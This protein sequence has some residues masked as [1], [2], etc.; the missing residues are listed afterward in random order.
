MKHIEARDKHIPVDP[1]IG[2]TTTLKEETMANM[3]KVPLVDGEYYIAL[4]NYRRAKKM[5]KGPF[6]S[7]WEKIGLIYKVK[8]EETGQNQWLPTDMG[9]EYMIAHPK[10]PNAYGLYTGELDNLLT[11]YKDKFVAYYKYYEAEENMIK[12]AKKV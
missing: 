5:K 4:N 10:Y 6:F 11:A 1:K 7:A 8:K 3:V 2:M 9:K 12:A